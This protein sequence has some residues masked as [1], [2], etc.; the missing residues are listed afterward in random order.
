[1]HRTRVKICGITQLADA[2]HAVQS[3]AD[4]LGFVFYAKSP[5]FVTPLAAASIIRQLPPFITA[6]GLVVDPQPND[7]REL[8]NQV[9]IDVLQFHGGESAEFCRQ[10][11]RPYLKAIRVQA[12][13]DLVAACHTY[14]DSCG[15]LLDAYVEGIPGGTGLTFNWSLIPAELSLPIVLAG[16]LTPDNV[17]TAIEQVNPWAV[18]V[19]GGVE[20]S[21][22]IKSPALIDAFMQGVLR[23]SR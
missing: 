15:L 22:G 14:R 20:Q 9:P 3:G 23:V 5:R 18:D 6:V 16:G 7:V 2:Q 11:A 21:K 19:S 1:M 13:T 8:L 10:F 12:S 4:A 17:A